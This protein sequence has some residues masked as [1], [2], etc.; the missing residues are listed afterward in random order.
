MLLYNTSCYYYT[1]YG[2][3]VGRLYIYARSSPVHTYL[4]LRWRKQKKKKKKK[5]T[6]RPIRKKD[7]LHTGM[8]VCTRVWAWVTEYMQVSMLV[9]TMLYF[10]KRYLHIF[11][12]PR[13][14]PSMYVCMYVCNA[15]KEKKKKKKKKKEKRKKKKKKKKEKKR[16]PPP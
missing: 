12:H 5:K 4:P 6:G 11:N 14:Y 2:R 10:N 7:N 13:L 1:W 15:E 3:Y 16:K 8:Y 9:N